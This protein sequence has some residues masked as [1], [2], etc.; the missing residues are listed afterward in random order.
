M[1]RAR[2]VGFVFSHADFT[3]APRMG[4]AFARA[5][6]EAG[7]R[8][9]AIAGRAPDPRGAEPSLVARL[10]EE[11]VE[12]T[13][14]PGL[15]RAGDPRLIAS[16]AGWLRRED[17]GCVVSVQ[18]ATVKLAGWAARL[19]RVPYVY[20]SQAL[21]QV[22]GGPLL[23]ALKRRALASTLRRCARLVV[24]PSRVVERT[25]AHEL[26]FPAAR[27]R[28][29]PNGID[30]PAP[31]AWS[32]PER[33]RVRAEL[34]A[35]PDQLLLACVARIHPLKGQDLAIDALARA[36]LPGRARLLVVGAVGSAGA[37]GFLRYERALAQAA[38]ALPPG[39]T[40]ALTG[41]RNDVPRLLAAADLF[42]HPSR[43]P[44]GFPLAV[45]EAMAAG[46]PVV[47]SD[48]A[49]APDGFEEGEHGFMVATGS[50]PSLVRGLERAAALDPAARARMG[51]T[52]RRLVVERLDVRAL[53][54]RF[55]E[56][57]DEAQ[58]P[59]TSA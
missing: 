29:L 26:A 56:L 8:V 3:G 27:L 57:V 58:R 50:L 17:V 15:E 32:T 49:G 23:A 10:E 40:A 6:R 55:V 21:P 59:L 25:L 46:L 5:C 43:F 53:G 45:I 34:G 7:R 30:P 14:L 44:E 28:Y 42:V 39:R 4:H 35:A 9:V 20:S 41:W 11:G 2:A 24:C 37:P 36:S 54:R 31:P 1:S 18:Q 19:A 12:V 51:A 48:C 22:A 13:S 33:E 16:L 38:A 52:A 47:F